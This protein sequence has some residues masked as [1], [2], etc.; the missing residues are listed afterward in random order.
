M[1]DIRPRCSSPAYYLGRFIL[2]VTRWRVEGDAPM[3]KNMLVIAA[4]HTS[5]WDA[6]LLLGAAYLLH[7]R[8]N[9]LV[10]NTLFVPVLGQLMTFFGGVPVE[11]SRSTNLVQRLAE[12]IKHSDGTALVVPPSGT[13]SYTEY[14]KSGFYRIALEANIPVVCGYLDYERKVAGLGLSFYLSGNVKEDMDRIRAF[15]EPINA[16]YPDKKSRIRLKEE[17]SA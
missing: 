2:F 17:E 14:W 1:Q 9:W 8:I 11:R 7:L 15:Y 13:R 4:P 12:R 10:K 16:K 6:I 3:T 5:N